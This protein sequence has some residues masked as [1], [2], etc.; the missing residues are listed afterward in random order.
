MSITVDYAQV[1]AFRD[2]IHMLAAQGVSKLRGFVRTR[3]VTGKTD[4]WERL[5]HADLVAINER[6]GDTQTLNPAHSRRRCTLTDKGG[7]ILLDDLD[8]VKMMIRPQSEYARILAGAAGRFWDDL[9]I[10]ALTGSATTVDNVDATSTATLGSGQQIAA[11]SAGLTYEKVNQAIRILN[12]ND[13]PEDGRVFV[14]SP[15]GLEDLL[16]ETEV[17]SSDFSDLMAIRNGSFMG[18]TWMGCQWVMST[19]LAISSTTRTCILFQRDA[20]GLSIGRDLT[21]EV[22]KRPDKWNS[23]QTMVKVSAGAVRTEEERVVQV[24]I[25]E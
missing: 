9:I 10:A 19:R 12:A 4:N 11:G 23:L 17:T 15:N 25:T 21:I 2:E 18:K 24:D 7:A 6:H 3:T 14:I 20:L 1:H 22:D 5:G 13:V 8:Q 16:L